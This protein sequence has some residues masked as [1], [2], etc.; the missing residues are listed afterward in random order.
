MTDVV[1]VRS[2][3]RQVGLGA[4]G[5]ALVTV[6]CYRIHLDLAIAGFLYLL[7]VVLLSPAGGFASSAIV[8]LIAVA[9]LDYF[10]T[11]PVLKLEISNPVD[12]VALVTY[13]VTSLIIT[14]LAVEAKQKARVAERKQEAFARLYKTAWRLFSVEPQAVSG[15][16]T[17]QIFREILQ[18]ESVCL[19]DGSLGKLEIAGDPSQSLAEGT[20][21][22][23]ELGRDLVDP[24]SRISIQCLHIAG[25]RIGAIGFQGLSDAESM[26]APLAMLTGA[27]LERALSFQA[28]SAAA[29]TSQA[30]ILRSAIVD[31]FAHQF[32]T[33]LAAIL[34][35][36]GGIREAHELTSQQLEMIDMV[37]VETVRL[38]RLATRLLVTARL[39]KDE[40]QPRLEPTNLMDLMAR[41]VE[42]CSAE[43]HKVSVDADGG[44]VE[45]A[46]DQE[47]LTLALAQ[48]LENAFKYSP[49]KSTVQIKLE[50]K[51]G[52]AAVRVKNH[53][54]FI[55]PGERERIFD[56]FYRGAAANRLAPGAGLG[57]YV[58]RKIAHAH[59]GSLELEEHGQ[60][61]EE[62]TFC[63]RLPALEA[64][65]QNAFKAS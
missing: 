49:P 61:A 23:Y 33:P 59:Q 1:T 43:A 2:T 47:L 35:A 41:I 36:A 4:L 64:K 51:N 25:K 29:A 46:A 37:E 31:A 48:L 62:T 45:A 57:L 40:V 63:L 65:P 54:S 56:R 9:C 17:L 58:A 15:P 22:A 3:A 24:S 11:P 52:V 53:G 55:A 38:N 30:E 19:F 28:A 13:L 20:L 60:D 12:G 39:D 10:F 14:R 32:K 6:I 26:A 42:Q 7:I 8:S 44:P 27:A 16:G 34:A 21:N 5:I 18:I 50:S